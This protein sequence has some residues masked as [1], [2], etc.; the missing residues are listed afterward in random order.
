M[1][2]G[3]RPRAFGP[4]IFIS[5]LTMM[6]NWLSLKEASAMCG[7]NIPALRQAIKRGKIR[8]KKISGLT[9][10][11]WVID[12]GSLNKYDRLPEGGQDWAGEGVNNLLDLTDRG[13]TVFDKTAELYERIL[14]EKERLNSERGKHIETLN[15]LLGDFQSRI[16]IL[17]MD[18]MGLEKQMRLLPAPPE[19][20]A[21]R[22]K[23]LEDELGK[24]LARA[25]ENSILYLKAREDGL[26]L[27]LQIQELKSRAESLGGQ[28]DLA[29]KEIERLGEENPRL[30]A[31]AEQAEQRLERVNRQHE[32]A[33]KAWEDATAQTEESHK[34][35]RE[36]LKIHLDEAL[37]RG[38][39][40][41]EE[42]KALKEQLATVS[43]QKER[44]EEA[45]NRLKKEK[46]DLERS[47]QNEPWWKNFLRPL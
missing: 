44:M 45:L 32:E 34:R 43:L 6:N 46:E 15:S 36:E 47:L 4:N 41:V 37:G 40:L 18:K 27:Q 20:V 5:G 23:G 14:E 12:P 10:D 16:Q 17:E 2:G 39:A 28:K 31:R 22:V 9:G 29:D 11:M 35:S 1:T 7:K 38:N 13:E 42:V 26:I 25:E 24:A 21:D 33:Q 19:R 30:L 8:G 3:Y